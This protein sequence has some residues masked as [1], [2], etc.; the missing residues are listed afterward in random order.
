MLT[1]SVGIDSECIGDRWTTQDDVAL[2]KLIAIIA[3]GQAAYASYILNELIPAAPAFSDADLR[4]EA[5]IRLTVQDK[6]V[7]PRI[8]YPRW[9]RDGFIFEAISWIAARQTYGKEVLLKDPHVSA[10]SQGLDGLMIE[11]APDKSKVVITTI[12]EDK[13]TDNPRTTFVQKVIPAFL[14]R[15]QNKRGA[16]LVAAAS[17]LL[18]TSNIA[19]G[20]AAK[21]AASVMDRAQRRYR[22]SFALPQEQDSQAERQKLFDGYNAL[23]GLTQDRRIGATYIVKGKI[24]DWFDTLGAQAVKY[25][26]ELEN[27]VA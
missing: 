2:A 19:D 3:M 27:G 23:K 22:A 25:L 8:G 14:D 5:R 26:N 12:L 15:H 6:A 21:L 16:E 24:R 9:Q 10:T 1:Q 11:L 18:R 7:S 20:S 13:C 4:Q 17:A